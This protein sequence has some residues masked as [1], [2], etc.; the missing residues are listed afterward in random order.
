MAVLSL[1]SYA[2]VTTSGIDGRIKDDIEYLPGASIV[3][4][5]LPSGTRYGAVTNTEGRYTLMGLRP[6][7]PYEITISYVG[8]EDEVYKNVNLSLGESLTINA[9]MKTD[10][11]KLGEVLVT[12][13]S[14]ANAT[15]HGA[16][17][18]FSSSK[19]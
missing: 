3:A 16:A 19:I 7:G 13:K 12:G 5:H 17:T 11:V 6:G 4:V 15:R 2:Q 18:S 8:F 10:D 14:S 1:T 9:T